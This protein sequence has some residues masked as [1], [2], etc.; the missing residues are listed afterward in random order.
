LS[1]I[2][3]PQNNS[4][5]GDGKVWISPNLN[6]TNAKIAW[7]NVYANDLPKFIFAKNSD[8]KFAPASLTKLMTAATAMYF[9]RKLNLYDMQFTAI[10]DDGVGVQGSDIQVGDVFNLR[11]ALANMG[12][13]SSNVTANVIARSIGE[14]IVES[15]GGASNGKDRFLAAMN[16]FSH[17]VLGMVDSTWINFNGLAIAGQLST[18]NDMIKLAAYVSDN[19]PIIKQLWGLPNYDMT[20]TGPNARVFKITHTIPNIADEDK[21][22]VWG[23]TGT[24]TTT[25]NLLVEC[26]MG[27]GGRYFYCGR[28]GNVNDRY[29]DLSLIFSAMEN[30]INP[31][32][33]NV[34]RPS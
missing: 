24:L 21:R 12:L 27:G 8:I 16:L 10:L 3:T 25:W 30:G 28:S 4:A 33:V 23:K 7:R 2:D 17:N 26:E 29:S 20:I 15:E 14:K 6:S 11:N 1:F 32:F 34:K 13:P 19:E 5:E 9:I 31:P 22:I 18:A